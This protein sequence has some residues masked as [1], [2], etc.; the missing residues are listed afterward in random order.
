ML[1]FRTTYHDTDQWKNDLNSIFVG[2][3]IWGLFYL[4]IKFT[5][6]DFILGDQKI[7]KEKDLDLRN[8][9]V[10]F[11][12]G[13]GAIYL[14]STEFIQGNPV[15]GATN[16]ERQRLV[17]VFSSSYFIYDTVGMTLEGLMD[18]AMLI[19]HPLALLGV[20]L[21]LFENIQGNFVMHALFLTELSN[22]AMH[23][24]HLLRLSGRVHTKA[25]ELC[26]LV[27][28]SLYFYARFIAVGPTIYKTQICGV[29]HPLIKVS[30]MGL[31]VQSLFFIMQMYRT[32][33]RRINE[34]L[35]RKEHCIKL[36]WITA[37]DKKAQTELESIYNKSKQ[38][39]QD[40]K[41]GI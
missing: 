5:P 23:F 14:T 18:K 17:M 11:V 1:S 34:V 31:F 32:L 29:N 40:A 6:L 4:I 22:P 27:F 26:E 24:R 38:I 10:S 7:S 9:L 41:I 21:P 15:C 35:I 33:Q 3:L 20:M 39:N 13:L 36:N 30:C 25:Y 37:L 19:H 16:T 12:H 2:S 28:I 8:R